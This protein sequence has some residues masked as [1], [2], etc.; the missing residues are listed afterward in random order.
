[1]TAAPPTEGVLV[2]RY[3]RVA[4]DLRV[5]LTDKCNLR[6]TYCMPAE[7]LPWLAGPQLL[8]D[9]EIVRLVRVAV[10]LLGVTEVRF[11]GGEPL[12]RPG[13]V[14]IVA[15]VAALEPRPRISLT[16]NGIGLDR[17]AATLRAAGLDRVNV[18][19]D[20]LDRDR[21]ARL[22]R[23]D[24]LDDVLAGLAGAARAGLTPVKINSVLM[25]GVNDDEAPA[26]LRFALDHGY[27]LRFIEQMPLDAQHGWDRTTMVTADEIL[28]TLRQAYALA[29]DPVV[30]GAAPAETWL[31]DGGPARVGV[32]GSVTRPFCG[33]CDRTRLTADGQVRNCLFATEE[34]DLRAALRG[35][36][37]DAELA[38]RWRAAMWG[39]RAGHGI[40]DP[41]FLQP[42]R[43]MS[44][45]G[46]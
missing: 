43:P 18:S 29:P 4:R 12:I 1:M 19:L 21:F 41:T 39:K 8:S 20:T 11:T 45:I 38:R 36:A 37:D 14:G 33:D 35:G 28:A 6:C 44:A 22:T 26:L 32:I 23:R 13:L 10:G 42:D 9:D 7:G 15:A 3:G 25:R 40:D 46:G 27:E 5:S 34:S 16:T 2:D 17:L 31:V 30:R 24:R